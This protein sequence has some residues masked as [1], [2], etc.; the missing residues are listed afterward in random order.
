MLQKY[1]LTIKAPVSPEMG[2]VFLGIIK[3]EGE[4]ITVSIY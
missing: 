3:D 1:I 4:E 2:F